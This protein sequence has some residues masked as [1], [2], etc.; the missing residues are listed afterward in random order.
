MMEWGSPSR[1]F[2]RQVLERRKQVDSLLQ[3]QIELNRATKKS[4]E[5]E[6]VNS[7]SPTTINNYF[8]ININLNHPETSSETVASFV[9]QITQIVERVN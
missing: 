7:C 6:P 2:D 9:K 1:K 3:S 8:T 5:S 4:L